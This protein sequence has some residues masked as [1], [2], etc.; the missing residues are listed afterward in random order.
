MDESVTL[1]QVKSDLAR[2]GFTDVE[3]R[4][5]TP[6]LEDVFVTLT[7]SLKE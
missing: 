1:D 2:E 5:I 7:H 6:S 4:T 3:T